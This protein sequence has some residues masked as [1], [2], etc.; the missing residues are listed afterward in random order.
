[1]PQAKFLYLDTYRAHPPFSILPIAHL[2]CAGEGLSHLAVP[3]SIAGSDEVSN[4]TALQEGGRGHRAPA[5][6]LGEGDHLHEPQS[7][8][9]C[10]GVVAKAQPITE[11]SPHGHDILCR[12]EVTGEKG[13][14]LAP[15]GALSTCLMLLLSAMTHPLI[16]EV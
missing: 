10:L 12:V 13:A 14:L 3:P 4:T 8:H 9:C 16:N 7:D 2:S 6:E 15:L 11:A 5:E 1:M